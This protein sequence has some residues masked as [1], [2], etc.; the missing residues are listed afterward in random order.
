[1]F[2]L[3]FISAATSIGWTYRSIDRWVHWSSE[4][5]WLL[6]LA[7]GN[8]SSALYHNSKIRWDEWLRIDSSLDA[9]LPRQIDCVPGFA[10][11]SRRFSISIWH[12]VDIKMIWL[13]CKVSPANHQFR[14][15]QTCYKQ[16][17]LE[18]LDTHVNGSFLEMPDKAAAPQWPH[19]HRGT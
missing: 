9:T 15:A 19:R 8:R 4:L 7:R 18:F 5:F 14:C 16:Y 6:T 1:M 10:P 2:N 11:G 12:G 13:M 17:A 3:I